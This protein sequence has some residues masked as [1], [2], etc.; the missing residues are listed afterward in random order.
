MVAEKVKDTFL[1]DGVRVDEDVVEY[2]NLR[3][4][5]GE[6]L[7]NGNAE[8]E[9]KLLAGTLREVIKGMHGITG[10][11]DAG[12]LEVVVKEDA[13]IGTSGEG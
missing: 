11:A 8:A 5:G 3:L 2:E 7:S 10:P 4:L 6:F 13:P 9:E 1:A 12:H